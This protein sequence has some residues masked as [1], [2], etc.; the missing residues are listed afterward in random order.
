RRAGPVPDI[1]PAVRHGGGPLV[2]RWPIPLLESARAPT[3]ARPAARVGLTR[4]RGWPRLPSVLVLHAAGATTAPGV[5]GRSAERAT[6]D[7]NG[8]DRSRLPRARPLDASSRGRLRRLRARAPRISR[9]HLWVELVE[10]AAA[11]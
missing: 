11:R 4:V 8:H 10:H 9:V 1:A 5:R 3:V 2:D 7:R 6:H